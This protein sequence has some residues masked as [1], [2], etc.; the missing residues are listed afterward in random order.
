MNHKEQM[1]A[2]IDGKTLVVKLYEGAEYYK[3]IHDTL[4]YTKVNPPI[5]DWIWD[6]TY[7]LPNC[8]A[9]KIYD[10]YSLTFL[11]AMKELENGNAIRCKIDADGICY[12]NYVG[13]GIFR[14]DDRC[15]SYASFSSEQVA[16]KWRIVK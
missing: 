13:E 11:E 15:T 7:S 9:C 5:G 14:K 4:A 1:Q 3:I 10:P 12:V 2:L 16:S 6:V 8:T